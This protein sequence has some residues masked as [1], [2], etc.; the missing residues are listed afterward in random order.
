MAYQNAEGKGRFENLTN[1]AEVVVVT[2]E[3]V[4]VI[5]V[6]IVQVAVMT[7]TLRAE[8]VAVMA[9]ALV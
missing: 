4:G 9:V 5:P 7:E 3:F 2:V 1:L 6:V 8:V